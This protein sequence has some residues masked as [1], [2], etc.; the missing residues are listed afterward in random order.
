LSDRAGRPLLHA[1]KAPATS[2]LGHAI[3][4]DAS[5]SGSDRALLQAILAEIR[6]LRADLREKRDKAPALIAALSDCFGEGAFTVAGLLKLVDEDPHA[7]IANALGVVID[8]NASARSRATALGA[9]L[10]RLPEVEIARRRQGVA[11]F[12]LCTCPG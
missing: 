7:A 11:I 5:D 2:T 9:L 3:A 1:A 12:R 8:L 6:G 10:A 4:R